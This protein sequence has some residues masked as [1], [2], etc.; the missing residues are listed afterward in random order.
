LVSIL[1]SFAFFID[2]ESDVAARYNGG[3]AMNL[4][5]KLGLFFLTREIIFL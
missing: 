3:K 1:S 2:A 5:L 4:P